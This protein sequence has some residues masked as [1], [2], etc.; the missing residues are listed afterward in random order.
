MF[1][2]FSFL[3]D[4]VVIASSYRKRMN[5]SF[6]QNDMFEFFASFNQKRLKSPFPQNDMLGS[7]SFPGAQLHLLALTER[8]RNRN[9]L[10]TICLSGALSPGANLQSLA[11][12]E[13]AKNR[14]SLKTICLSG[15]ISP[16]RSC[17]C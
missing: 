9:S 5:L 11:L 16:G 14:N 6:S 17:N 7:L 13:R 10:K 15:T 4:A 8:A 2:Q 3:W 12:T 1:K